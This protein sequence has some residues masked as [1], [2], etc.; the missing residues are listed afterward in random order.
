[1][2]LSKNSFHIANN[3]E[4]KSPNYDEIKNENSSKSAQSSDYTDNKTTTT[5]CLLPLHNPIYIYSKVR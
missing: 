5:L 1:M 2:I 4:Y 3:S